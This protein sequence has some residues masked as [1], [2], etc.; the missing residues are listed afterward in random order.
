MTANC[1]TVGQVAERVRM[2]DVKCA[3][4]DRHAGLSMSRL[5]L[6][7]D[8]P[9][10]ARVGEPQAR[11][12]EARGTRRWPDV[13]SA[14]ADPAEAVPAPPLAETEAQTVQPWLGPAPD[15]AAALVVAAA[16]ILPSVVQELPARSGKRSGNRVRR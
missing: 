13:Q 8:A 3:R 6:G 14:C 1:I 10:L 2:L 12:S 7:P 9:G 11:L 4:C 15:P 16:A 5:L